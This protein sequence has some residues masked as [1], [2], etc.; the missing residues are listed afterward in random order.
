MSGL[1]YRN[2]KDAKAETV[3]YRMMTTDEARALATSHVAFVD[4]D[5]NIR[6]A[7]VNGRVRTWKRSPDRVEV[8]CKYGLYEHFTDIA[9]DGVMQSL[10]IVI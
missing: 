1:D 9:I 7:K 6:R 2:G 8:P 3:N 4:R 10:V 5:G